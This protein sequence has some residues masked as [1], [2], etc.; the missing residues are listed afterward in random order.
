MNAKV[1]TIPEIIIKVQGEIKVL[2]EQ[3]RFGGVDQMRT[4]RIDKFGSIH[5]DA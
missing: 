3:L 1:R 4:Q 5:R 2:N